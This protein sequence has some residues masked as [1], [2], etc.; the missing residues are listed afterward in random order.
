MPFIRTRVVRFA[1]T[2]PRPVAGD[3]Q[4]H[5]ER[6]AAREC[7]ASPRDYTGMSPNCPHCW[8]RWAP[9]ELSMIHQVPVLGR[10]TAKSVLP[11]P[12]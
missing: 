3:V 4:G 8:L 6:L 11:S 9:L 10:Q 2:S 5:A 7:N 12:S 1:T